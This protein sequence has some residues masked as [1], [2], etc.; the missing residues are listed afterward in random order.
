MFSYNQYTVSGEHYTCESDGY[1][2]YYVAK[3]APARTVYVFDSNGV[4]VATYN[5][6]SAH[7]TLDQISQP[8]FVR[9]GCQIAFD[10]NTHVYAPYTNMRW[11]PL[12]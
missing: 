5:P 1:V 3:G 8:F 4:Q 2:T 7:A 12:G 6:I 10:D 11:Y 9:K